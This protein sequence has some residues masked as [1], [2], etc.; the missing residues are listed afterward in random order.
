M[1][2]SSFTPDLTPRKSFDDDMAGDEKRVLIDVEDRPYATMGTMNEGSEMTQRVRSN[3]TNEIIQ[4]G[5]EPPRESFDYVSRKHTKNMTI[6]MAGDVK[7]EV[8]DDVNNPFAVLTTMNEVSELIQKNRSNEGETKK[9]TELIQEGGEPPRESFND[10]SRKHTKSMTIDMAGDVK[11]E[12]VDEEKAALLFTGN[13][14]SDLLQRGDLRRNDPFQDESRDLTKDKREVISQ[15]ASLSSKTSE[16]SL[17]NETS[18]DLA[19]PETKEYEA[20]LR[21]N[22]IRPVPSSTGSSAVGDIEADHGKDSSFLTEPTIDSYGDEAYF[23]KLKKYS[24]DDS[25]GNYCLR[26]RKMMIRAGILTFIVFFSLVA[27][28]GARYAKENSALT[29]G[30]TT[31]AP[32]VSSAPSGTPSVSLQPSSVPSEVPSG[33]PSLSSKPS[34]SPSAVPSNTQV[35]SA[36]PSSV[37]SLVPSETPSRAPSVR[38]SL[39]LV[40]SSQPSSEPSMSWEPTFSPISRNRDFKL[41]LYWEKGYKWQEDPSEKFWCVECANCTDIGRVSTS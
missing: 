7:R 19:S 27:T 32:S 35:P 6:D 39:S 10:I 24:K 37:P 21:F 34:D 30:L 9:M 20:E 31:F 38:P 1:S 4:E 22:R 16:S 2:E 18:S 23:S 33:S 25:C 3:E 29:L 41:R 13:D 17:T 28:L 15:T 11:R 12:V 26:N 8:V 36:S 14:M 40:P 5:G